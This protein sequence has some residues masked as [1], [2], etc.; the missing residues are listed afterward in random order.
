MAKQE[1]YERSP[2]R[3]FDA[4]ANGGLKA[5]ELGLI[6]AKK[7]SYLH[8]YYIKVMNIVQNQQIVEKLINMSE[9]YQLRIN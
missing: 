4:A 6:T 9:I 2:I 3:A 5:G 7:G 8:R 1:L